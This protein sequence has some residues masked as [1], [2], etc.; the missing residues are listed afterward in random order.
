[1]VLDNP[2]LIWIGPAMRGPCLAKRQTS[3]TFF[4][5]PQYAQMFKKS[6]PEPRVTVGPLPMP[7]L[8]CLDR[9][10]DKFRSLAEVKCRGGRKQDKSVARYEKGSRLGLSAQ[11]HPAT[12]T[13]HGDACEKR[14]EDILIHRRTIA[15]PVGLG[16]EVLCRR[17]ELGG[18]RWFS[19]AILGLTIRTAKVTLATLQFETAH[20]R[21]SNGAQHFPPRFNRA[22]TYVLLQ[23]PG[24]VDRAGEVL[25][26]MNL[27]IGHMGSLFFSD[28][29]SRASG[30]ACVYS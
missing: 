11:Q 1:M 20:E 24:L 26:W 5:Y 15:P 28:F 18:G 23:K 2:W 12:L 29:A 13:V 16:V 4:G 6:Q 7:T 21:H 3:L 22:L 8:R 10:S 27:R 14:L 25:P 17:C 30:H 9:Q 19:C